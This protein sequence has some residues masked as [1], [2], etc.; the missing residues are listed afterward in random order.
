MIRLA[1]EN[2]VAPTITVGALAQLGSFYYNAHLLIG[3]IKNGL[4]PNNIA[5]PTRLIDMA[6]MERKG[7]TFK[8]SV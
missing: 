7:I 5:N 2:S 8:P 4:D 6:N 1:M 3:E